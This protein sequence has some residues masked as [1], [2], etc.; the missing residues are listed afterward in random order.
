MTNPISDGI[1]P[2]MITPYNSSNKIDYSALEKMIDWYIDRGVDGLFAVCQ[3]SEMWHLSLKERRELTNFVAKTTAGRVPIMASGH[4][5]DS[6][7]DQIKELQL[8]A[9]A[10]VG[11]MVLVTNR[12][13]A[14]H[15]SDDTFKTNLDRIIRAL[16]ETLPLGFYECPYPY[17]RLLSPELLAHCEETGRFYFL[18]DTSCNLNHMRAKMEAINGKLKIFNANAATLQESLKIGISGYSGVM[19]N[20][21]PELYVWA[22]RNW[23][24]GDDLVDEAF[25]MIGLASVIERQ[26]YPVNAKYHMQLENLPV[27]LYMRG[28]DISQFTDSEKIEVQQLRRTIKR[29]MERLLQ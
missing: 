3:S 20:F 1:W 21:H 26:F 24:R 14:L 13:A 17:K 15:E 19:A 8:L 27:E 25:D 12:L 29:L 6:L 18:K 28:A 10:G 16:P 4:V 5:A 22:V 23:R 11:A 9:D 7:D 2:T